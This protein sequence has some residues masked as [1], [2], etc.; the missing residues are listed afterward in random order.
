MVI[1][2]EW[3]WYGY[4]YGYGMVLN[5]DDFGV[6]LPSFVIYRTPLWI[7]LCGKQT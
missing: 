2:M 4:G 3:F 5:W 1:V 7:T 6:A